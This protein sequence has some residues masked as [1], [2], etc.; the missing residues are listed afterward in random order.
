[1]TGR[2]LTYAF[3]GFFL[4]MLAITVEALMLTEGD[5]RGLFITVTLLLA[6][7]ALARAVRR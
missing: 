4:I 3:I 5:W 1:M 6:L 7:D 2:T